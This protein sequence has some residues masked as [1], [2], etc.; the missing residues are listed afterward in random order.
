M[1]LKGSCPTRV[2]P[3]AVRRGRRSVVQGHSE[4]QAEEGASRV[5]EELHA[6][7]QN[8]H[9]RPIPRT[10]AG[11]GEPAAEDP[12]DIDWVQWLM[13]MECQGHRR[14]AG[15][16]VQGWQCDR[17]P[18]GLVTEMWLCFSLPQASHP[19]DRQV[20]HLSWKSSRLQKAAVWADGD[21]VRH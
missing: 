10:G 12:R 8:A 14:E 5:E 20:P 6:W 3:C 9:Q 11:V 18:R 13:E 15:Q 17:W 19:R 16:Q 7:S 21:P 4:G 2:D 1:G